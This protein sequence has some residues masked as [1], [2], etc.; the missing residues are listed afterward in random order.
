MAAFF[1]SSG[2][3]KSG[4]PIERL[5]G[6]FIEAARSKTLRMPEAST[7]LARRETKEE[8]SRMRALLIREGDETMRRVKRENVKR[9]KA[10]RARSRF[11]FYV[12]LIS[13]LLLLRR[14][15][16]R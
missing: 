9:D 15:R 10:G 2:T 1:A 6:S 5:I 13:P 14:R 7:A 3:S 8:R 12:S 11:T 4:S 16:C